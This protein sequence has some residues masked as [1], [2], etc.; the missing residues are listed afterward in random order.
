VPVVLEKMYT[1]SD[2]GELDERGREINPRTSAQVQAHPIK[3]R[4]YDT[5]MYVIEE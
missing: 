4:T 1:S 3:Y 5:K 2:T